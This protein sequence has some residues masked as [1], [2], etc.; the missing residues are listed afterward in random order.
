MLQLI[1]LL[2]IM[3]YNKNQVL[4]GAMG[5]KLAYFYNRRNDWQSDP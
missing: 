1:R 5:A 4:Q 3:Y 2:T